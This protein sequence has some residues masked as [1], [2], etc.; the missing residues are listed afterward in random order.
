MKPTKP[1]EF[2]LREMESADA[3]PLVTRCAFCEW[4]W[5]GTAIEGREKAAQHR[6]E[7]PEAVYRKRSTRTLSSFKLRE[8]SDEQQQEIDVE[9]QKRAHLLGLEI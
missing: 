5:V 8:L 4:V 2:T 6:S 7:H 1:S 9:R 3:A